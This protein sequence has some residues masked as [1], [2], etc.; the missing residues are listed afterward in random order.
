MVITCAA[1]FVSAV[2]DC[3]VT[4]PHNITIPKK[5]IIKDECEISFGVTE[6]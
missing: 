6:F 3:F 4:V 2:I 5:G 1:S